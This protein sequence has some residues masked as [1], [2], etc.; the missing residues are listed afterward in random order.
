ME[1]IAKLFPA[2]QVTLRTGVQATESSLK[3]DSGL[4]SYGVLHF[5]VHGL[6]H[7]SRPQLSGLALSLPDGSTS[8]DPEDGLL[9]VYEIVNLKLN[10]SLVVLSACETGLGKDVPGEGLLGLT[11]AFL[12]AGAAS[13]AVSLWK[14]EDASTAALMYH[15]YR[16]LRSEPSVV[17]ALRQAKLEQIRGRTHAH[18]YYWAG[19]VVVG[20]TAR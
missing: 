6:L 1:S 20:R 12:Y 5:A 7:R 3:N 17:L 18:P 8:D 10:A 4:S 9:Q 13:V 14:V 19:F 11:Q 2:S 15:V 16:R